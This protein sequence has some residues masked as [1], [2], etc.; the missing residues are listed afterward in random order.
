[1]KNLNQE[2]TDVVSVILNDHDLLNTF[3][4]SLETP[5]ENEDDFSLAN[6]EAKSI[7]YI[8]AARCYTWNLLKRILKQLSIKAQI[9]AVLAEY[10]SKHEEKKV[11]A[12][13]TKDKV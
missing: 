1:M 6:I 13:L 12:I 5:K 4:D 7:G 2:K 10:H 9:L 3:A 8:Q 11:Q